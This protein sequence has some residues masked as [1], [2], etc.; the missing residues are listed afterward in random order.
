METSLRIPTPWK[1]APVYL[2]ESTTSTMDDALAL[3]RAGCPTGTTVAAGFQER[4]RG[5]GQ[6][7]R[8]I[9]VA[10]ESLLATVV[11]RRSDAAFPPTQLSLRAGLAVSLA[12][13]DAAGIQTRI[14]WP[15]DLLWEGR[16]LAGILCEARERWLLVGIGVNC[17]QRAFP[18]EI[19]DSACSLRAAAGRD[20]APL[21]L[22]PVVLARLK[23]CLADEVWQGKVLERL[24]FRETA[25]RAGGVD[26]IVRGLEED[27]ALLLETADGRTVRRDR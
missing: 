13:E 21:T 22:L 27:G 2:R 23:E 25:G 24:A 18:E 15:N 1:D 26:G 11:L 8:W 4:G 20:I 10:W 6:H 7:S 9:S 17:L 5:R 16:K 3:A 12:V 19:A 14:K